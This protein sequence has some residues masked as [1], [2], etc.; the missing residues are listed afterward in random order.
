[1]SG[2]DFSPRKTQHSEPKACEE[3]KLGN[4]PTKSAV[5]MEN[6]DYCGPHAAGEEED[7]GDGEVD[8]P[9]LRWRWVAVWL[10]A[11]LPVHGG[12]NYGDSHK[13]HIL[14]KLGQMG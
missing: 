10:P 2:S 12:E 7:G 11:V 9:A 4:K 5:E 13:Q 14:A 8:T 1:M 3:Q 6:S